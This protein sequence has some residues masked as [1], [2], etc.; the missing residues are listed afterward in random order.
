MPGLVLN[1][2][3]ILSHTF[4]SIVSNN[5]YNHTFK[6]FPDAMKDS[7]QSLNSTCSIIISKIRKKT[8]TLSWE[9]LCPSWVYIYIYIYIYIYPKVYVQFQFLMICG[10]KKYREDCRISLSELRWKND[11]IKSK[12]LFLKLRINKL[13]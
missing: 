4:F 13:I 2:C 8:C 1:E 7:F 11:F 12:L 6:Y 5:Y 3:F 10:F 9:K